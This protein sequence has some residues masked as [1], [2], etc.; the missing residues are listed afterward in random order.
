MLV[1]V[2]SA[3]LFGRRSR[4]LTAAAGALLWLGAF[5]VLAPMFEPMDPV[6]IGDVLFPTGYAWAALAAGVLVGRAE[7]S[8]RRLGAAADAL[9]DELEHRRHQQ[10]LEERAR[11]ARE[12]NDLIVQ[13][14]GL[15][16]IETSVARS[17]LDGGDEAA[18]TTALL[19]VEDTGRATLEDLRRMLG[20]LRRDQR[21]EHLEP[22]VGLVAAEQ[23]VARSRAG[24]M[25]VTLVLD[26]DLAHVPGSVGVA[27]ARILQR[28][29]E[30]AEA[31]GTTRAELQ[32][33]VTPVEVELVLVHDGAA[34]D[35]PD[36][37]AIRERIA[38]YGGAWTVRPG[39]DGGE[40]LVVVLPTRRAR[41][42]VTP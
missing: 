15:M 24:G 28:L 41:A 1:L 10:V 42:L 36:S 9:H 17:A 20:V 18:A 21:N 32:L 40:Q 39:L 16:Q 37:A 5:L 29:L 11:I 19:A 34:A 8:A 7:T 30:L 35:E 22:V 38:L 13:N 25:D 26:G 12:L 4:P 31:G 2:A 6:T 3:W 14:V 23:L 33:R 27:M